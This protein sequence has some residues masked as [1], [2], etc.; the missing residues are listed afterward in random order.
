MERTHGRKLKTDENSSVLRSL[1]VFGKFVVCATGELPH[2][3][4][5][6]IGIDEQIEI[7]F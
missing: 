3:C 1:A 6:L 2:L 4:S 7:D 5:I